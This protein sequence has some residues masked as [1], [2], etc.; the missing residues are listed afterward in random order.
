MGPRATGV[1]LPGALEGGC[2]EQ[3]NPHHEETRTG[4][5]DDSVKQTTDTS[6]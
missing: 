2:P 1:P 5:E 6:Y 4:K 3:V